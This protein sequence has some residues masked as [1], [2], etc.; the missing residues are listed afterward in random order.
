MTSWRLEPIVI[1]KFADAAV[2]AATTGPP[3][4]G[5]NPCTFIRIHP[6]SSRSTRRVNIVP[7]AIAAGAITYPAT[8]GPRRPIQRECL[9]W[10][11]FVE[12]SGSGRWLLI[13]WRFPH[14]IHHAPC[15][16]ADIDSI[17]IRASGEF[18]QLRD[19]P[20]GE[21]RV[22]REVHATHGGHRAEGCGL[23]DLVLSGGE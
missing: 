13:R 10:L 17:I 15:M 18:H 14:P 19:N 3:M 11:D 2:A 1:T 12:E 21:Y 5:V 9:P 4:T 8:P 20:L 16:S 22:G 6:Y 23:G 7:Q